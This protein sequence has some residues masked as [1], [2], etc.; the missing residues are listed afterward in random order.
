[1]QGT[2][3]LANMLTMR[4]V[5]LRRSELP[6]P[7]LEE[8]AAGRANTGNG[9]FASLDDTVESNGVASRQISAT[10][11]TTS[12]TN[13]VKRRARLM[14]SV[15]CA[16][17]ARAGASAMSVQGAQSRR[18]ARLIRRP[19]RLESRMASTTT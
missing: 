16:I 12:S 14:R 7:G 8:I 5:P 13:G 9:L 4:G 17:Q 1:M 11:T 19:P 10:I 3:Q 2:H 18:Q 6:S 15:P